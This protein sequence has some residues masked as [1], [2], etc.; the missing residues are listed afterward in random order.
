[1]KLPTSLANSKFFW[2]WRQV[3]WVN[4]KNFAWTKT[5]RKATVQFAV[6]KFLMNKGANHQLGEMVNTNQRH[7]MSY[8]IKCKLKLQVK[9]HSHNKALLFYIYMYMRHWYVKKKHC[10]KNYFIVT[11]SSKVCQSW[12]CQL[13][14]NTSLCYQAKWV[15]CWPRSFRF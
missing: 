10:K 15:I 4:N 2:W 6:D 14:N 12:I 13:N 8:F 9:R 3:K 5:D 7:S 11:I 1:M